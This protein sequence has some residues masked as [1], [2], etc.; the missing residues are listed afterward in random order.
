MLLFIMTISFLRCSAP[1]RSMFCQLCLHCTTGM[2]YLLYSSW[3]WC[4]ARS[5]ALSTCSRCL[6]FPQPPR[7]VG[8]RSPG[9]R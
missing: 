4:Q 6:H 8:P 5:W 7:G 3:H 2:G 1:S 9:F